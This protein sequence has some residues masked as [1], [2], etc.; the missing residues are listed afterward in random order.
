[1]DQQ[2]EQE[3]RKRERRDQ[4]PTASPDEEMDTLAAGAPETEAGEMVR[5][6]HSQSAATRRERKTGGG[7]G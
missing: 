6:E 4:K 5:G 7:S 3:R 1:M 2:R